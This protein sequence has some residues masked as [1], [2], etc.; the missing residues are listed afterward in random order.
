MYIFGV[1]GVKPN[2]NKVYFIYRTGYKTPCYCKN[3]H[4]RNSN[5]LNNLCCYYT[6]TF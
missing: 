6:L 4:S 2:T 3:L 5:V 1:L